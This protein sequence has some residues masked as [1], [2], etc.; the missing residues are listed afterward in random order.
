MHFYGLG[1]LIDDL[2]PPEEGRNAVVHSTDPEDLDVPYDRDEKQF[3]NASTM[4]LL[5]IGTVVFEVQCLDGIVVGQ[6]LSTGRGGHGLEHVTVSG[7]GS[8]KVTRPTL[9]EHV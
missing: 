6:V 5:P 9:V 7:L 2:L 3:A 4:Q 1:Q 8:V